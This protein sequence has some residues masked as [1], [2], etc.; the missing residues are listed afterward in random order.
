M[1]GFIDTPLLD[2]VSAD[3]NEPASSRLS[4]SGLEI[5][6]V[7]DVARAAWDAVHGISVHTPV[8]KMARRL[9]RLPRWFP[10]LIVR[11]S[12]KTDGLGEDG[13]RVRRDPAA[14]TPGGGEQLF[15]LD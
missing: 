3:S 5:S 4:A 15:V 2:Q 11:Q 13:H 8:G 7:A 10:G 14:G 1:P 6:P 12:K 9:S